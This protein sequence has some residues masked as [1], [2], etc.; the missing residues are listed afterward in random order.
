MTETQKPF[1]RSLVKVCT[2]HWMNSPDKNRRNHSDVII[3]PI[4][5]QMPKTSSHKCFEVQSDR[6]LSFASPELEHS[7][8]SN[9]S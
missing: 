3:N 6:N 9:I 2:I 1:E 5:Q 7:T 8:E 4:Q